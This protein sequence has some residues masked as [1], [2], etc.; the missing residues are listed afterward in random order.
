LAASGLVGGGMLPDAGP[1]VEAQLS[2]EKG[3]FGFGLRA[4]SWSPRSVAVSGTTASVS[5]QLISAG[6]RACAHPLL[7]PVTVSA[8]AGVDAGDMHGTGEGVDAAHGP[9]GRWS[10]VGVGVAARYP[11]T[12]RRLAVVLSGDAGASLERPVFGVRRNGV[13]EQ[14]FQPDT[15]L[16]RAGLGLELRL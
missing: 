12:P 4:D 13:D 7:A 1:G 3:R 10:A 15:L 16:W 14:T 9:H 5:V 6:V 8:C 11:A 2:L